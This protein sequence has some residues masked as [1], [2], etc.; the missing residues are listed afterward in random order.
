MPVRMLAARRGQKSFLI[1][2]QP[3]NTP[4]GPIIQDDH[5]RNHVPSPD[6]AGQTERQWM[7][8]ELHQGR[9]PA[10]SISMTKCVTPTRS[11]IQPGPIRVRWRWHLPNACPMD[12][13]GRCN[14]ATPPRYGLQRR[15]PHTQFWKDVGQHMW[16]RCG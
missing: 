6:I 13:P 14:G 15:V 16:A 8:M 3:A 12:G 5:H 2:T 10:A 9:M 7:N 11:P 4:Q 1:A